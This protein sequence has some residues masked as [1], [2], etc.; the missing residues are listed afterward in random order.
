MPV[1]IDVLVGLGF[2]DKESRGLEIRLPLSNSGKGEL[3]RT[4]KME[5]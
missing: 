5:G 4:G 1:N 2:L 3:V